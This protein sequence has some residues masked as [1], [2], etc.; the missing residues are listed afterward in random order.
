[1]IVSFTQTPAVRAYLNGLNLLLANTILLAP[2]HVD[3]M[4]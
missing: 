1:M 4:R 2:A 3:R